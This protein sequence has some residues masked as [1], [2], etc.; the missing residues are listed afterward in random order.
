MLQNALAFLKNS[1]SIDV[2]TNCHLNC[3]AQ[4]S[5]RVMSVSSSTIIWSSKSRFLTVEIDATGMYRTLEAS[6]DDISR[7][8]VN[9]DPFHHNLL[10][11][12]DLFSCAYVIT[13]ALKPIRRSQ[14]VSA[15]KICRL[16]WDPP[17]DRFPEY[18]S[19]RLII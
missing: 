2:Q 8:V 14:N 1:I 9:S 3:P 13:N 15:A 11:S 4:C 16:R 7:L 10:S 19:F 18:S 17:L 12:Y 5:T 6:C